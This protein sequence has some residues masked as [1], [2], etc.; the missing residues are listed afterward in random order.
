[1]LIRGFNPTTEG[2]EK[3]HIT[4]VV[5]VG[6]TN[7]RIKN[8]DRFSVDDRVMIGEM[9]R[10]KTE[11]VTVSAVN[12][13]GDDITVG[14]TI[15][16]H[17]VDDPIYVLRFDQV[18]FERSTTGVNGTF[19][20]LST[21]ELD[22]DNASLETVYDD[23]DGVATY[24][25][26]VVYVHSISAVESEAS[27]ANLGG[28]FGRTQ[29]GF[30]I[31]ELLRE[32]ND[33]TENLVTRTELLGYMNECN[34]ELQ[35]RTEKPYDFLLKR[36]VKDTTLNSKS[37]DLTSGMWKVKGISYLFNDSAG[38][39]ELRPIRILPIEE[40]RYRFQDENAATSDE[41][42][43]IGIDT[44][45]DKYL[46]APTPKTSQTGVLYVWYWKTFTQL[47]SE[48]DTFETPTPRVYKLFCLAKIFRKK[49]AR[50]TSFLALSDRYFADYEREA[51]K[52]PKTNKKDGGSPMSFKFLPQTVRGQRRF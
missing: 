16:P 21:Q 25:Y 31:D 48:G 4:N 46:L 51:N 9:G 7:I 30:L 35:S 23:T 41:L 36:E 39:A 38:L 49:G 44:A 20:T 34:D 27:D 10:E 15:F 26:R 12:A 2:L 45:T 32:I 13:D 18:R 40:F 11:I 47:D 17:D 52:L 14:A 6:A 29:V 22:V 33:P 24:A 19:S 1:M 43:F 50:D 42:K 28:A 5:A 3:S 8:N 37:I